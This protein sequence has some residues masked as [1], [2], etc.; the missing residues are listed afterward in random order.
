M[1][2]DTLTIPALIAQY[3]DDLA[4]VTE[5]E[6][7]AT[8]AEFTSQLHTAE[9]TLVSVGIYMAEGISCAATLLDQAHTGTD[10]EKNLFLSRAAEQLVYLGDAADEYRDMV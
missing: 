6:T 7:A 9:D 4:F 10:D 1:T 2:T 3:A 5:E 8:L